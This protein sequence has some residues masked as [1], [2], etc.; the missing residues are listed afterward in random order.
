MNLFEY[1]GSYSHDGTSEQLNEAIANVW[2][3]A[4]GQNVPDLSV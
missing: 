1:T 4:K 2:I 3:E